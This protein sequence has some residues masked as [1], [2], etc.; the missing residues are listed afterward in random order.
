M[1]KKS[2]IHAF[3][4]IQMA[5]PYFLDCDRFFVGDE[6]GCYDPLSELKGKSCEEIKVKLE[7]I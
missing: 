5:W 3:E 4:A 1:V 7:L 2:C 6:E